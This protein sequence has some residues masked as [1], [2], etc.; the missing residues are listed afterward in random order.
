MRWFAHTLV[1]ATVLGC[2]AST[3]FNKVFT[4]KEDEERLDSLLVRGRLA[5]DKGEFDEAISTLEEAS[6]LAPNSERAAQTLSYSYLG[7]AGIFPFTIIS[8]LMTQQAKSST[9]GASTDAASALTDFAVLLNLTPT[10][11]GKMGTLHQSSTTLLAGLDVYRPFSPGEYTSADAPRGQVDTLKYLSKAL[12]AICPFVD[13]S[14][15]GDDPRYAKCKT[16][17]GTATQKSQSYLITALGHLIEAVA[18]NT[19]LLYGTTTGANSGNLFR[20]AEAIQ[21]AKYDNSTLLK[22]YVAAIADLKGDI[23]SIFSTSTGSMLED[24]LVDL[25]MAVTAFGNIPGVPKTV[26]SKAK[27]ALTSLED[28]ATTAGAKKDSISAQTSALRTQMNSAVVKKI[29]TS[30]DA[31]A[32]SPDGKAKV[33]DVKSV[34]NSLLSILGGTKDLPDS[35]TEVLGF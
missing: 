9:T 8:K 28:A 32:Q 33:D 11:L 13:V 16:T 18:F 29:R 31:F 12:V 2:G 4:T 26:T 6:S 7:K 22:D 1:L 23:D 34:C 27:K 10:D 19:M 5:Y 25:R 35:C 21:S 24:T 3:S 14:L 30:V 15:L 17:K 20:R